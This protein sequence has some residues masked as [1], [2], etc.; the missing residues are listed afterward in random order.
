MPYKEMRPSSIL[1]GVD[2]NGV[3]ISFRQVGDK[4][5][6]QQAKAS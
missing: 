5:Q 1:F 6:A 2:D 3:E 4:Q